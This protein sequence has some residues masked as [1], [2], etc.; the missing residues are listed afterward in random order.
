MA[1]T[2]YADDL[3]RNLHKDDRTLY[4]FD[5]ALTTR[6]SWLNA[7][8]PVVELSEEIRL[9]LT[10]KSSRKA[11]KDRLKT[12]RACWKEAVP[13]PSWVAAAIH[14]MFKAA[15]A[16]I[17]IDVW[18]SQVASIKWSVCCY[19]H[20][21]HYVEDDYTD[22]YALHCYAWNNGNKFE[23]HYRTPDAM[24]IMWDMVERNEFDSMEVLA[25]ALL[26]AGCPEEH[27]YVVRDDRHNMNRRISNW[28]IMGLMRNT[29]TR[30]V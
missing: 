24:G 3:I 26:D 22:A 14:S 29:R 2:W 25:D 23:D 1:E 30:E 6:N 8:I 4:A 27:M 5:C 9:C 7:N 19:D 16:V 11:V 28:A 10:G 13:F 15:N 12:C 21:D 18:R 20:D 17:G